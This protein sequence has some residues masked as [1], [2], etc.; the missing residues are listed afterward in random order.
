MCAYLSISGSFWWMAGREKW[1]R[2]ITFV[3][4]PDGNNL[5]L[6]TY[7]FNDST[8]PYIET[9]TVAYSKRATFELRALVCVQP[10]I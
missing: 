6:T 10:E 8:I 4:T 7:T 1:R 9:S 3:R 2:K 5:Y